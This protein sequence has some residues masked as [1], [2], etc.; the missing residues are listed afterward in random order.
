MIFQGKN[1]FNAS[2]D[3]YAGDYDSVRPGYP[4]KLFTDIQ[5]QCG[6]NSES[7]LLEIGSGSG[8][9]TTALA[10]ISG[11]VVGIEPGANLAK[12]ARERTKEFGNVKIVEAM[13]EN[14]N[15]KAE[16]D[17][18]LAFTAFHW[19][20]EASKYQKAANLLDEE[21]SLV[22][23][24]NS[25]FQSD[26]PVTDEVN[27][28]YRDFLPSVYSGESKTVE[29]NAGVLNKLNRREQEISR[30]DLFYLVFLQK[31]LTVYHYD[32]TAYPKLLNTFPKIVRVEDKA[33]KRFL[34]EVSG[35]IKR[36]GKVRVPILTTL[37]VCRKR[38]AFLNAV[39]K[40]GA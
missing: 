31:Y 1:I 19:I 30:N 13:F 27:R 16:F 34:A 28:L 38:P 21:G 35:T 7:R 8:I 15:S 10:K 3:A 18:V 2:F 37:A 6:I 17:S 36:L 29:V 23:V 20:S 26:S 14:Y 25:F 5:E 24:W 22:L 39:G 9:A 32:E 40:A 11:E 12:I 4:P 33:R